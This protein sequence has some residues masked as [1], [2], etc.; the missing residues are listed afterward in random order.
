MYKQHTMTMSWCLD[1]HRNP[2]KFI[3]PRETV[4]KMGWKQHPHKPAAHGAKG[5]H[6]EKDGHGAEAGHGADAG[7]GAKDA[8]G[9]AADPHAAQAALASVKSGVDVPEEAPAG[10]E[11]DMSQIEM[12]KKLVY[13]YHI[14]NPRQLTDCATCHH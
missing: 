13:D 3:R 5:G 8:H 2:E 10:W 14:L 6:G 12:G 1:C 9:A 4:Y 11:A 7:H